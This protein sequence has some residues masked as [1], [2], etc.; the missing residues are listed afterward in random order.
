MTPMC[1]RRVNA[2]CTGRVFNQRQFVNQMCCVLSV[3]CTV[4]LFVSLLV[5]SVCLYCYTFVRLFY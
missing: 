2:V 3:E 4:L 5:V 1:R